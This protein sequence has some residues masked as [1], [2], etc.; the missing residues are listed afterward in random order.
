MNNNNHTKEKKETTVSVKAETS[1]VSDFREN[2]KKE[3]L[4]V[5]QALRGF[6]RRYNAL[7]GKQ[8]AVDDSSN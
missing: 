2:V 7:K 3:D 1:T 5:S 8:V 4:T 6:M